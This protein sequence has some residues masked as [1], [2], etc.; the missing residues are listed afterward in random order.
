MMI[1]R[2]TTAV[3]TTLL[4]VGCG[5]NQQPQVES[6]LVELAERQNTLEQ[7]MLALEEVPRLS[8]VISNQDIR[9]DEQMFQPQLT[10]RAHLRVLGDTVPH[11]FYVDMMLQ[12]E[13]PGED[14]VFVNRQVFPV[15]EG[16]AKIELVQPLPAHGLE[17]SDIVVTMRPMN[18]Y[19]SHRIADDQLSYR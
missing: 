15:F 4:L 2:Q 19:G 12:L 3:L 9:I 18:W 10:S 5:N 8:F 17:K 7:R 6:A 1:R 11:T 14:F 13:V 16:Q